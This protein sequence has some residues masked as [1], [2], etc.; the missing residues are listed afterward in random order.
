MAMRLQNAMK[1]TANRKGKA[2]HVEHASLNVFVLESLNELFRTMNLLLSPPG[3]LTSILY[4]LGIVLFVIEPVAAQIAPP[5]REVWEK[6]QILNPKPSL[7]TT[8][9]TVKIVSVVYR[10][11]RNY[12]IYMEPMIPTLKLTWPGL[13]PLTKESQRC[14]GSIAKSEQSGCTSFEFLLFGSR[15]PGPGGRAHTNAEKF[16]NFKKIFPNVTPRRGPFGYDIYDLGPEEARTEHYRKE[17]GDIWFRCSSNVCDDWFR[18]NDMN[19]MQ[20]FFRRPN[21]EQVPEIEARMRR[22]MADFASQEGRQ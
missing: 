2:A 21:I 5:Y 17:D 14:F 1:Y 8:P 13:Q 4:I 12:L 18:L 3:W 16:E 7:D 15:G 19:H 22:I 6:S 9:V 10:I 11:P 20:F